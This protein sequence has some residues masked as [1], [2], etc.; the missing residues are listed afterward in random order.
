M[1]TGIDYRAGAGGR[2]KNLRELDGYDNGDPKVGVAIRDY[3]DN[4]NQFKR[5]D[6]WARTVR[7][8]ENLLFVSGRHYVNDILLSRLSNSSDSTVGDLTIAQDLARN[9]PRPTNDIIGRYI[10]TN[11]ALVTEN[12]PRPRVTAKSDK[13]EDQTAAELSEL[14]LEYLWEALNMPEKHREISRL[15]LT[16]GLALLEIGY[17]P[18]VPRRMQIPKTEE[19]LAVNFTPGSNP[20]TIVNPRQIPVL[21]AEGNPVMTDDIVYGDLYANVVSPFQ[22]HFPAVHYWEDMTWVMKEEFVYLDALRDKYLKVPKRENGLTKANG[23]NLEIL[24]ND[25][26]ADEN[27]N[28]LALWWWEWI[29]T[30]VE[31]PGPSLY[32]GSPDLWDGRCV[33]RTFDRKPSKGWPKGR[34]IITIGDQVLYDS[35]KSVGA[36]AYNPRWP[37]RW[38]PYIRFR[39][40]A[41]VG[42]IY[43]RSLV[44]KL[45]PY[46]KRINNID[47]AKIMWRRTV[48]IATWIAPKGS[49]PVEDLWTGQPGLIWQYDPRRTAGMAPQPVMP[50]PFP[51]AME[52]ERN[53]LLNQMESIAGTEQILRGER[54]IGVNSA[55]MIDIL[56]KQALASRSAQLQAWDEALQEEGSLL[57]QTVARF[58]KKDKRYAENIRILAREKHSMLSIQEEFSGEDLSDNVIVRVDTVSLALVS[59]EARQAKVI[60]IMQYLPNLMAIDD[61]GLRQALLDELDLKKALMPNGPDINRAKKMISLIRNNRFD[62]VAMLPEDDP[63]IFHAMLVNEM[64]SDG[65]IDL[66]N[67]QQQNML[68]LIEIYKRQIQLR[69][70]QMQQQQMQQMVMMAQMQGQAKAPQRPPQQ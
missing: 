24:E 10:E 38:H 70:M 50:P 17:D 27:I 64:K 11:V 68:M 9:L 63:Y 44:S 62:R 43:G 53:T 25:S 35:P 33:V 7:W 19:E 58:V 2:A 31:G 5:G 36:R 32:V 54:P 26:F 42:N 45:L 41:M 39:G 40:E 1:A 13:D 55:A 65:F 14:T 59:R 47:T 67:D 49:Q 66:P 46:I 20:Q 51:S 15:V 4:V 22:M 12:R 28:R 23:W 30:L 18:T 21:D 37:D 61:I 56:R 69:E 60:E 8:I 3:S 16:T 6:H 57:L 29:A 52:E 34:T 48:P